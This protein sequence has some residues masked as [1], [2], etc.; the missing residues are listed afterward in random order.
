MC[1]LQLNGPVL[2]LNTLKSKNNKV[3]I[4]DIE[5]DFDLITSN[6]MRKTFCM[7]L[8]IVWCASAAW[9]QDNL[10]PEQEKT[11]KQS[12]EKLL[13]NYGKMLSSLGDTSFLRTLEPKPN[14]S[15]TQIGDDQDDE[16]TIE[17]VE[18][19]ERV[20]DVFLKPMIFTF[21]TISILILTKRTPPKPLLCQE[22]S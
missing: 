21:V 19:K 8:A 4:S 2:I 10:T 3:S 5:L 6:D 1:V 16:P 17:D 18:Y 14:E 22:W 13:V 20:V 9:A 15:G 12:V 11:F 7:L